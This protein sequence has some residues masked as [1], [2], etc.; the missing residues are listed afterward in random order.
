MSKKGKY[1]IGLIFAEDPSHGVKINGKVTIKPFD[2]KNY[3]FET[4]AELN[5]FKQGI[6]AMYGNTDFWSIGKDA[7]YLTLEELKKDFPN[8][9]IHHHRTQISNSTTRR[10]NNG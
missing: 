5:A 3:F 10:Y 8:E 7:D 4:Q 2:V 9:T 6:N 1:K